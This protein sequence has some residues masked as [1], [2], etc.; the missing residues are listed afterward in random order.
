MT[1]DLAAEARAA[2]RR[3]H[4]QDEVRR[5]KRRAAEIEADLILQ[6]QTPEQADAIARYWLEAAGVRQRTGPLAGGV[7][8]AAPGNPFWAYAEEDKA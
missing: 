7:K 8:Q 4:T 6:G 5:I 3:R 1:D 2:F